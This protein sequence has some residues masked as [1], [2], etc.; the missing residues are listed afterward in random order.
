MVKESILLIAEL[1]INFFKNIAKLEYVKIEIAAEHNQVIND[2]ISR[3]KPR[4]RDNKP[5]NRVIV[6]TTTSIQVINIMFSLSY[7]Y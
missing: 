3:V 1:F 4:I 5:E 2:S 7:S 6:I